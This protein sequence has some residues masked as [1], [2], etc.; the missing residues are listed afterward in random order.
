MRAIL[1]TVTLLVSIVAAAD[2]GPVSID[3]APSDL[4][5][6]LSELAASTGVVI[7]F[8]AS[9]TRGKTTPGL[10]GEY[11]VVDALRQ[12]L[13]DSR[14][15]VV[16]ESDGSYRVVEDKSGPIELSA[17]MVTGERIERS[18]QDTAASVAVISGEE[19]ATR[20]GIQDI[21][22]L[23]EDI[24]NVTVRSLTNPPTIR[25]VDTGGPNIGGGAL[26]AGQTPRAA[27]I[28]DG[29]TVG[30]FE[31]AFGIT[32]L[33]DLESVE[34]FRGPQTTSQGAN[35]IAGAIYLNTA[36]PTFDFEREV[37]AQMANRDD[38]RISGFVSGPLL[39]DNVA[40]RLSADY[41]EKN[42]F[43]DYTNPNYDPG[44][45]NPDTDWFNVRGKLL[46]QPSGMPDF[47]ALITYERTELNAPQGF[48]VTVEPLDRLEDDQKTGFASY[49]TITDSVVLELSYEL[50]PGI[51]L[52]NR[53]NYSDS[54][55]IRSLTLP[56][57]GDADLD[58]SIFAN[59][60]LLNYE[61]PE[62]RISGVF[63]VYY[64]EQDND[65]EILFRGENFFEGGQDSLG[66]FTEAT[67]NLTDR[68][69]VTA[70]L[71]YQ[72]DKVRREGVVALLGGVKTSFEERYDAFLPKFVVG[73]DVAPNTRIGVLVSRGY[74]PGGIGLSFFEQR[75]VEYKEE[76]VWNYELFFRSQKIANRLSLDANIFYADFDDMQR[77]LTRNVS[78]TLRE[79]ITIN[80]DKAKSYGAELGLNLDVNDRFKL[81]GGLGL[82]KTELVSFPAAADDVDGNEFFAAPEITAS[83][84]FQWD[85]THKITLRSVARYT[86]E[87][88]S[89][90]DN[91]PRF[92]VGDDL[93]LD[94]DLTGRPWSGVEIVGYV[95]NAF[96]EV[97]ATRSF[98]PTGNP[99]KSFYITTPREFGVR[100]KHQF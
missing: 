100:V 62:A 84:G 4:G 37:Q 1:A 57:F 17:I 65:D 53:T 29:R 97:S 66:I 58:L 93:T 35:S 90:D 61:L 98:F 26:F 33:Y 63:G 13:R 59:E 95:N 55:T 32:G 96:N 24:P 70:G 72:T 92:E 20:A 27:T 74:N 16:E 67:Y 39:D 86:G 69:D 48:E 76:S 85:P 89:D 23:L 30:F 34:V 14:L 77:L 40:F 43:I 91:D 80:A 79:V 50:T 28:I 41:F 8:D 64:R 22:D 6:A 18:V 75:F 51:I 81:F 19:I 56:T 10:K 25:G 87:Y 45:F 68:L 82:L 21:N 42:S 47:E 9:L 2:E 52:S 60:T 3:V 5:T 11:R 38:H 12:L 15:E 44:A 31:T 73:Y 7:Y 54:R 78:P 71:R 99:V 94:L 46:F 83:L 49:E 88:Y 36:D